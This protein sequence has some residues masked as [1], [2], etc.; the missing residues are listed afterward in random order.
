MNFSKDEIKELEKHEKKYFDWRASIGCDYRQKGTWQEDYAKYIKSLG[1]SL[2]PFLEVGGAF[3]SNSSAI[4]DLGNNV[5][6]VDMS[7]HAIETTI[8]KNQTHI[9][10][11]AEELS[12]VVKG[13]FNFLHCTEVLGHIEPEK[14]GKVAF[15]FGKKVNKNGVLYIS[16]ER[17]EPGDDQAR[18][19]D[20][21]EFPESGY[22]PVHINRRSKSYWIEQFEKAGFKRAFDLETTAK[23]HYMYEAYNWDILIF[24]KK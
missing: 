5:T 24:R 10:G 7:K 6:N 9:Q 22:E 17:V 21:S 8:H 16:Y 14:S 15:E 4:A 11:K 3:G 20:D 1:V 19:W 23:T 2:D 18:A 13:K 12:K